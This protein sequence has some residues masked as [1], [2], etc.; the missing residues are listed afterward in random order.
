GETEPP[1][2]Y[3]Y[4]LGDGRV[5]LLPT[6]S[7]PLDAS[8]AEGRADFPAFRDPETEPPPEEPESA[9]AEKSAATGP[10]AEIRTLLTEYNELV[11]EASVEDL[12]EY[13]V[14]EQADPVRSWLEAALS[15]RTACVGLAEAV[16]KAAPKKDGS[17]ED[18]DQAVAAI[19]NN[20]GPVLNVGALT[21]GEDGSVSGKSE[22]LGTPVALRFVKIDEDWYIEFADASV[23]PSL[24]PGLKLVGNLCSDWTRKLESGEMTLEQLQEVVRSQAGV[25]AGAEEAPPSGQDKQPADNGG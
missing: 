10:E 22:I 24:A 11:P 25:A 12:V 4:D 6:G 21:V 7:V 14:E 17:P 19:T 15:A 20:V 23:L 1:P 5:I 8:L 3:N 2:A 18:M 9:A 16:R 13:Y